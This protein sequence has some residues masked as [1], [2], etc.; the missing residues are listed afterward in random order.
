MSLFKR[1][2]AR[3]IN[4][5]L[6]RLGI[7]R[8]ATKEAADAV[9]DAVGDQMPEEPAGEPVSPETAADVAATLVDA[10]NKLVE[11]TGGAGMAEG[12]PPMPEEEALKTSSAR[13]LDTRAHEQGYAVMVKAAEETKVAVGS[14]IEGGDKGNDMTDAPAGETQMEAARRPQGK[15]VMGVQGVGNTESPAGRGEGVVGAETIPAPEAPGETPSGDNTVI[16]QSKAGELRAIIQKVAMGSTI[17]GGD[18]GNTLGMAAATTG[19]GKLEADRRPEGYA[20]KGVQAVGQSDH[21]A[22]KGVGTVGA[23]QPHPHQPGESPAGSTPGGSGNT[24]VQHSTAAKE[25]SADPFLAL[26]RKTAEEVGA[27][28]PT[29][30]SEDEK[31]GH[32]RKLMGLNDDERNQYI[33]LLHKDAGATDDEAVE[34]AQKHA[35]CT[36]ERRR[37]E[38]PYG[39]KRENRTRS[40]QKT[41]AELTPGQEKLPDAL[42]NAIKA[43]GGSESNGEPPKKEEPMKDE[44]K[45]D[46]GSSDSS[47]CGQVDLL[48]RIRQISQ[49][50][51]AASA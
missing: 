51:V 25:G 9:A 21:P 32:I 28:L 37:Y 18:K 24:V 15:Y 38:N 7:V 41:G 17:S 26:F 46:E 35:E 8:Y 20:H 39:R 3:G 34:A 5:E 19:E 11:E 1:A 30:L 50:G 2:Y 14:T 6:V 12:A 27:H 10:A 36:R 42:K 45:K 4:D 23:E 33:G 47:K 13:D 29:N 22:G 43:K 44:P 49:T 16:E 31:V 48:A 40:N